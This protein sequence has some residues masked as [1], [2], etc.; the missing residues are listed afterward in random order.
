VD[1][2]G[3]VQRVRFPSSQKTVLRR[4]S[5][6]LLAFFILALPCGA[7][8][9]KVTLLGTG[10]P[11]PVMNRFGP[12]TVVQAGGQILLFDAGRGAIQR[13]SQLKIPLKNV[14]ALFLTHL[15]SDHLVGIPDLYLTGWLNGRRVVPFRVW[16]PRGTKEMMG[17]IERAFD[18]DI[19]IRLYDDRVPPEG[20]RNE[21]TD[22]RQGIV[23]EQGGV[24]VTAFDVDHPPIKPAFGYRVDYGGRSVLIS[25]DTRFSENL[26][27]HAQGVDV[28]IHEVVSS[29]SLMDARYDEERARVITAH[30]TTPEEAGKV[31]ER[32]KP[33]LAIY[34]HI[35]LPAASTKDLIDRTRKTYSGDLEVGEDLMTIVIADAVTVQR[36]T[37]S[38][39]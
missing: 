5:F 7:D 4:L 24:K 21:A 13:L 27:N 35:I 28:L 31:F 1:Y 34:S 20:I 38:S 23:Y 32:V 19:R 26:I 9:F 18:F 11:P 8:E 22:I 10:G 16:G 15:H 12:S 6:L 36:W 37:P 25:G 14:D 2:H 29:Q 39:P 17:H 3:S 30:H 33:K